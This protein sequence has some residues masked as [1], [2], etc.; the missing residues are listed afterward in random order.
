MPPRKVL[1]TFATRRAPYTPPMQITDERIKA[2]REAYKKA[3]CEEITTAEA[4]EMASRLLALYQL[5]ARPL[6]GA[7][8]NEQL[9]SPQPPAR[10]A[11]G[12]I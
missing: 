4:R 2:F 3:Y 10:H 11:P 5:L 8:E 1:S 9:P 12:G 6:P 7:N